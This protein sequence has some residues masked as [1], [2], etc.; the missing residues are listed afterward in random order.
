MRGNRRQAIIILILTP[1]LAVSTVFAMTSLAPDGSAQATNKCRRTKTCPT[2]TTAAPTPTTAPT[3]TSTTTAPTAAPTTTAPPTGT[4]PTTA[5]PTATSSCAGVGVAAGSD[6]QAAFDAQPTGTTFCLAA[7][8]YRMT[9][10][11]T[12]K[13]GTTIIGAPGTVLNGAAV[14]T[15]FGRSGAYWTITGQTQEFS[16][17]ANACEP[18]TYTG[19]RYPDGV[20]VDNRA[21]RQ[22]TALSE[23]S[24]GEFYF[25]H[26]ADTIYLA[27]DPAGRTVEVSVSPAAIIGYGGATGQQGVTVRNLII[28]KFAMDLPSGQVA[29][30]KAG[31]NWTIENNEVRLNASAGVAVN[32]GTVLRNNLLH[33]NGQYGFSGGPLST[34]LV[35]GNDVGF[36]NTSSFS[37]ND[38]AGG[39]KIVRGSH[40]TFRGNYVHDNAGAGL[41]TDW[42]NVYVTYEG[43]RLERNT[44]AGIFHEASA[45]A[46]I[47]NNRFVGN[48]TLA[49]GKSLWWSADLLLND[50]R[51]TEIYGNDIVAGVHGIGLVDTDRGSS[52]LGFLE[53]RNVNVHDNTVRMPPGGRSGMVGSRS[54][55]Y[56][57]ANN[58]FDRNSYQLV[59]PSQPGWEWNG[60]RSW[61]GWQ[62]VGQDVSGQ[63]MTWAP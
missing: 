13:S 63:T 51:N 8:V 31:W 29:P 35:E 52:S 62:S 58:H 21:L 4:S 24:A 59:D 57:T 2:T 23:L 45:D 33:D 14:R 17:L 26:G 54:A 43:N 36:N 60:S 44:G 50:S 11:A 28:E 53:I 9:K 27:D 18:A 37:H 32:N 12:P 61:A 3:T 55:A 30:I 16:V 7:G 22:V 15:S 20:F 10:A 19:C 40:L 47:R 38:D 34:L 48:G 1:I 5:G 41:W 56:T 42:D 46:V 6:L 39:A 25:D 49:A